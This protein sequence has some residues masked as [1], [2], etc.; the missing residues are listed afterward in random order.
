MKLVYIQ[1]PVLNPRAGALLQPTAV[2][3]T[4]AV[5]QIEFIRVQQGAN[6][7]WGWA[8]LL[9]CKKQGNL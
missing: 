8:Y 3:P 4:K 7:L 2:G 9:M 1:R 6:L 5:R